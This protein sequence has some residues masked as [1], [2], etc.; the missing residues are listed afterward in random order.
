LNDTTTHVDQVGGKHYQAETQHWDIVEKY[1]VDYLLGTGTKYLTRWR[2]KGTPRLDLGKAASYFEKALLC[3]PG[4]GARR[5]VPQDALDGFYAANRI[6]WMDAELITAVLAS[7]SHAD[8]EATLA[9]V[10]EMEEHAE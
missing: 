2:K 6:H 1:D 9:K 8:I 7:G 3:R 5:L 10:R 4:Q